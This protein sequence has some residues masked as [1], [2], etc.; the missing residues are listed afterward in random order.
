M[1]VHVIIPS[2]A[3]TDELVDRVT[4]TET[5]VIK[6]NEDMTSVKTVTADVTRWKLMGWSPRRHR[7]GGAL[8]SLVT[9]I[10]QISAGFC[11]A[12]EAAGFLYPRPATKPSA[13]H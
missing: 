2:Y 1:T 3:K 6:L 5:A 8:A 13:A 11:V 4:A 12:D 9:A 10:G 7:L